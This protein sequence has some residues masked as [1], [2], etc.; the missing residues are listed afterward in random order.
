VLLRHLHYLVAVATEHHF[1]R[2]AESCGVTQ[3]TLS[4]GIKQLEAEL[5]LLIVRR[6]R[7]FQ[8][9]TPEGKRVLEWAR[10]IVSDCASLTQEAAISREG[11]VGRLRLGAIPTAL[12]IVPALTAPFALE[13]PRVLVTVWSHTSI[14]IQA[15]LDDFS[16][17]AGVTYLDNEPL[18]GV[19]AI[20]LYRER[21]FLFTAAGGPLGRRKSVTWR[22]AAEA[23]L[24]LLT[25]DM[26]NRRILDAHFLEAGAAPRPSLETNSVV[27]L[28]SHLRSGQWS[29]VLP[30]S[31]F[32]LFGD[33]SG[34]RAIP[35]VEPDVS[36]SVG[37][38]VPG[39]E[40]LTPSARHLL[41][42]AGRP[43]VLAGVERAVSGR[44]GP[45]PA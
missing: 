1:A 44:M 2:A 5:G 37:L 42:L 4:N 29:S 20:P 45:A 22:E 17:D 12:P 18:A 43:E 31:F 6:G 40:P 15:G 24:C 21:Y 34:L 36:H 19:R 35:V 7:R 26:Q 11:L 9:F 38:V 16:L 25:P 27:T 28:C 3:P 23:P 39:R 32:P 30:Q 13:H 41:D 14:D 33:P 8:G 10:L